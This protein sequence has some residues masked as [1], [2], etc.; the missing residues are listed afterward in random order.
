M[1]HDFIEHTG[2]LEL[3]LRAPTVAELF[4]EAGHAMAQ[5]ML[6]DGVPGPQTV[7]EPVTVTARGQ[8]AL[9]VAWIDELVYRAETEGAVFT[10]FDVESVGDTELRATIHGARPVAF[11][12]PVKAATYHR[13]R[14]DA[15]D[16]G[17]SRPSFSTSEGKF[18]LRAARGPSHPFALAAGA[19]E[20]S[21][22]VT[23]S[24]CWAR[25]REGVV[26]ACTGLARAA[27]CA[28]RSR[29][30]RAWLR[31]IDVPVSTVGA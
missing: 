16:G 13:L 29:T 8:A 14:L 23:A 21:R 11:Q 2:E 4:A 6:G 25:K 22:M 17:S 31:G 12:N 7:H 27:G 26:D 3:R 28:L 30:S 19:G 5:L 20:C 1:P 10:R 18:Q 9:L 24:R 15:E